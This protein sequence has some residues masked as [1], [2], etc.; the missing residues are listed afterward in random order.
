MDKRVFDYFCQEIGWNYS[1]GTG[2]LDE[3]IQTETKIS[4]E[5]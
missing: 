2:G 4:E 1:E 3:G 5:W